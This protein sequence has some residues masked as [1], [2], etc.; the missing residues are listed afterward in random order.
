MNCDVNQKD[1]LWEF[2]IRD[3]AYM[4]GFINL[5]R[6]GK[7]TDIMASVWQEPAGDQNTSKEQYK[8][9]VS[10]VEQF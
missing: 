1:K 9:K 8:V 10:L 6:G 2:R 4:S 3:F 7:G 5:H